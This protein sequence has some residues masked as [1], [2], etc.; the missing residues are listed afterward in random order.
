MDTLNGLVI[1][2]ATPHPVTLGYGVA[3]EN[4]LLVQPDEKI[5]ARP[6]ER[7]AGHI[8]GPDGEVRATLI[9]TEFVG[10]DEGRAV[11]DRARAAGADVIVGSIIAAQAYP[12]DVVAMVPCPGFE[13]V[14]PDQKRMRADKFTT[15]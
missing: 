2:N 12:G 6:V 7:E 1:F 13:R 15:F 11:I 10:T 4:T 9:R 8:T 5:D 14:P 3:Y